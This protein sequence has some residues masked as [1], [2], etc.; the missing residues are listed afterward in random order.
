MGTQKPPKK[1]VSIRDY[2]LKELADVY[3]LS[4]YLMR[5]RISKHRKKIG[6]PDG[7]Y[8]LF[9]QVQKIFE[10]IKLPSTVVVV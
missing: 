10:L 5:K 6:E 1:I 8:Y 9:E 2:K 4:P 7:Q 3:G